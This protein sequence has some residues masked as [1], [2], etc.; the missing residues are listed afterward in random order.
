MSQLITDREVEVIRTSGYRIDSI[1]IHDRFLRWRHFGFWRYAQHGRIEITRSFLKLVFTFE[2]RKKPLK[3]DLSNTFGNALQATAI[4]EIGILHSPSLVI[5]PQARGLL[6][7]ANRYLELK[8]STVA[9]S[10]ADLRLAKAELHFRLGDAKSAR[11][12]LKPL[13]SI[14][15]KHEERARIVR[16][17]S[18]LIESDSVLARV[19]YEEIS[20]QFPDN[21]KA[22]RIWAI[23]TLVRGEAEA[24]A[25]AEKVIAENA[26]HE[27]R[28]EVE[29]HLINTFVR[30]R[31]YDEALQRI[32]AN[33]A[34]GEQID[35]DILSYAKEAK[36]EIE[37]LINDKAYNRR[38]TVW[39]PLFGRAFGV[40]LLGLVALIFLWPAVIQTPKLIADLRNLSEL[41]GSGLIAESGQFSPSL[42]D[43]DFGFVEISYVFNL[44]GAEAPRPGRSGLPTHHGSDV[45]RRSAAQAILADT[46][47]HSVVYLPDSPFTSA[48][49][50]ISQENYIGVIAKHAAAYLMAT[51][52][53]LVVLYYALKDLYKK[54]KYGG[55]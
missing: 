23:W 5:E 28:L 55:R 49:Y 31:R 7:D 19:E 6:E 38:A 42:R 2:G 4:L 27:D 39:R 11:K 17:Q 15:G 50:P 29:S 52:L 32:N 1:G 54:I 33:L 10:D 9:E 20:R 26:T 36:A 47:N 16:L 3:V 53:V 18:Y 45:L 13:T 8:E 44:Q 48:V 21:K 35:P 14:G 41:E 46:K 30:Q 37:R 40:G 34:L 43:L 51:I 22:R 25:F 24:E 12:E